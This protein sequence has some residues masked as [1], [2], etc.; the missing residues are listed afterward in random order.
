[1]GAC[2]RAIPVEVTRIASS[3]AHPMQDPALRSS[4]AGR[5]FCRVFTHSS[6]LRLTLI[7][8]EFSMNPAGVKGSEAVTDPIQENFS[9]P[10]S[11]DQWDKSID[12][13]KTQLVAMRGKIARDEIQ[14]NIETRR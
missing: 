6:I 5:R 10:R 4:E 12:G 1:M 2:A 13:E 9:N 3:A 11:A 14:R 8:P 7:S